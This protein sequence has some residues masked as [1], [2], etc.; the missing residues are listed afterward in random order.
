[1]AAE[2]YNF[3]GYTFDVGAMVFLRKP[4]LERGDFTEF[5]VS[6]LAVLPDPSFSGD[7]YG[8]EWEAYIVRSRGKPGFIVVRESDLI[9]SRE[10]ARLLLSR[11]GISDQDIKWI[12]NS[13][14]V[15]EEVNNGNLVQQN[16]SSR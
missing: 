5:L 13:L 2:Q 7:S 4:A 9:S 1:M 15:K 11:K 12:E 14:K 3:E 8:G 6:G 10:A 16:S